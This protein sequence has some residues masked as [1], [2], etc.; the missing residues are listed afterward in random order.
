MYRQPRHKGL[1]RAQHPTRV[2][3]AST[4]DISGHPKDI[5]FAAVE[6]TRM[7]MIVTNPNAADNP[8]I[9]ANQAFLDMTGYSPEEIVGRNCRFLQGPDTDPEVVGAIR[10]AIEGRYDFST[11]ILNYRKDGS[12]FW[13]ALFISPIFN[14]KGELVYFF[15]SQLDVSR[16][17]DAEDALHQSQKM[18]ALGQLTGGIAHDFNNLLQVMGGYIDLI[19]TAAEKPAP[20][21]E[22][23]RRST[24]HARSA[25][26]KA[27]TLTKQLLAFSR[28]QKLQGRVL[29]LN[30]L[31]DTVRPL[32]NRTFG[33]GVQV[34][35]DL[36]QTLKNCRIDPTQ[37]E[38]ALLNIFINSR[39]ALIGRPR[40]QI[41]IE[42]RNVTVRD[43][44]TTSYDGLLPGHYVS[45]AITDNGIG[46]P[47]SIRDRVMDPFFTTKEE[48]KGSGLG[49]SMVYGFAKQ[50]GGTARIYTEEG[51]GTTLRLYFPV[52][53]GPVLPLERNKTAEARNGHESVLIVEDR[54]D[55]A[56]LAKM[57][58]EDYGYQ[59]DL[60]LNAREA[61]KRFEAG[62]RYDLLFTDLIMP[63]GMNGVML[64][65]EVRRN[66][67]SIKVLLT[68]GYAENSIERTDIGGSE[69]EVISKPYLPHDL[70]RKVRQVLDSPG[71]V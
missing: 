67:P 39:D 71:G 25:V 50:S 7:P 41:F 17:R 40:P 38:V 10:G 5:F 36:E 14:E 49:L 51:I 29:N 16:R 56:E 13:N 2:D 42:T 22:R 24:F 45:L 37:A 31:V 63:G 15:A 44:A 28:K 64:A 53:G 19:R 66:H 33:D 43:L 26:D 30:Q 23:I 9:F 61:L 1:H 62:E 8:I 57:V 27:S 46:M 34:E 69:F 58:L 11:E 60:V 54:P 48:G 68:T 65:R 18:E 47:A 4:A 35:Y 59:A 20:D 52:D 55:V 21:M 3:D 70:A 6:T 12:S 32:V